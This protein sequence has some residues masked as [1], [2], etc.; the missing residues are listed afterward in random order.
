M[1]ISASP[2]TTFGANS[3][4]ENLPPAYVPTKEEEAFAK[5]V[6][7]SPRRISEQNDGFS[8]ES[9]QKEE[10]GP[11]SIMDNNIGKD[12]DNF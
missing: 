3:E 1:S 10:A 2:R 6:Y 4:S 11:S 5:R 8:I 7:N 12:I 9:F